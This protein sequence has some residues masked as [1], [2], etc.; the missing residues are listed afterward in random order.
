MSQNKTALPPSCSH[1]FNDPAS[2]SSAEN[3]PFRWQN[4]KNLN[5]HSEYDSSLLQVAKKCFFVPSKWKDGKNVNTTTLGLFTLNLFMTVNLHF[6]Y[7]HK[8]IRCMIKCSLLFILKQMM[9]STVSLPSLLAQ[10]LL[11]L[12]LSFL[13]GFALIFAP[14]FCLI[15]IH[16][17]DQNKYVFFLIFFLYSTAKY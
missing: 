1:R 9:H 11:V 4:F 15:V 6:L 14:G 8:L 16:T 7:N 3:S 10:H 17:Q 12:F 13:C 2:C 5:S